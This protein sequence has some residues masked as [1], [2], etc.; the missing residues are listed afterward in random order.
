MIGGSQLKLFLLQ[1]EK[2]ESS[3]DCCWLC[4]INGCDDGDIK[5]SD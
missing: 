1:N 5:V 4:C 3:W 2:H